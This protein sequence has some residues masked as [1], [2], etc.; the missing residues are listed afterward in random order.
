M[1]MTANEAAPANSAE[2]V[3]M[4]T[5]QQRYE[6]KWL[7]ENL[8]GFDADN[9]EAAKYFQ[10]RFHEITKDKL[11]SLGKVIARALNLTLDREYQRRRT[12]MLLWF[13]T[14]WEQVQPVLVHDLL[15]ETEDGRDT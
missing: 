7:R 15:V 9:C 3:K 12:T 11:L 4:Q 14:H 6:E 5:S 8:S 10:K 1:E 2:G 13:Q